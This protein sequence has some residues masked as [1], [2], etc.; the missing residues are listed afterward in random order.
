M[1]GTLVLALALASSPFQ[2]TARNGILNGD[3]EGVFN[4]PNL[5]LRSGFWIVSQ[6][7]AAIRQDT[8]TGSYYLELERLANPNRDEVAY[9]R[10]TVKSCVRE[11]DLITL[12]RPP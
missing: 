9:Q 6:E 7:E 10:G 12:R 8:G 11:S 5:P 1:V 3:F 2:S 4:V